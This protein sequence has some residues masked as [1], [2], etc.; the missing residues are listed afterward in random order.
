MSAAE[1]ARSNNPAALLMS[2]YAGRWGLQSLSYFGVN[3]AA[4]FAC[5]SFY[6]YF[7]GFIC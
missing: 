4:R 5:I 3:S 1:A 6:F 7:H 2:S